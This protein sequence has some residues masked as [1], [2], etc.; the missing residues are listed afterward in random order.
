M[1]YWIKLCM[2][3]IPGFSC[4]MIYDLNEYPNNF[5]GGSCGSVV[6]DANL[7]YSKSHIMSQLWVKPTPYARSF[8]RRFF[9]YHHAVNHPH[10]NIILSWFNIPL[11]L[12]CAAKILKIGMQ[13]KIYHPKMFLNRDFCMEILLAREVTIFPEKN[14]SSKVLLKIYRTK[15]KL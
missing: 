9:A 12:K 14:K 10:K 3:W 11:V 2:N 7:K 13:I 1:Q 6:K 8:R 4:I 15:T 5:V